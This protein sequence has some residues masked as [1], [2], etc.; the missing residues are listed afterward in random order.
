MNAADIAM[1]RQLAQGI[2]DLTAP[3]PD[4]GPDVV[5]SKDYPGCFVHLP[6][7]RVLTKQ[8]VPGFLAAYQAT[9][10]DPA[11][12]QVHQGLAE[13]GKEQDGGQQEIPL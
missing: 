7:K 11:W 5:P 12:Q 6:S 1:I 13:R 8:E 2:L 10:Q 9:T 3:E 4:F